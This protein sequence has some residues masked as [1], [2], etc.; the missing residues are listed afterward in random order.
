MYFMEAINKTYIFKFG[1][2]YFSSVKQGNSKD[3]DTTLDNLTLEDLILSD[4]LGKAS[5]FPFGEEA[6]TRIQYQLSYKLIHMSGSQMTL[7]NEELMSIVTKAVNESNE[8]SQYSSI[9]AVDNYNN[10]DKKEEEAAEKRKSF[11]MNALFHNKMYRFQK[12]NSNEY[13][14]SFTLAGTDE[15]TFRNHGLK[16]VDSR[17]VITSMTFTNDID[18]AYIFNTN[19]GYFGYDLTEREVMD[20]LEETGEVERFQSINTEGVTS[21]KIFKDR[22]DMQGGSIS[23]KRGV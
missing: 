19:S 13:L 20:Y 1:D 12:V 3:I 4:D 9:F 15:F 2:K 17:V 5:R 21:L 6:K 16:N 10:S 8:K 11:K 14:E 7:Y 18:K 22:V 23:I